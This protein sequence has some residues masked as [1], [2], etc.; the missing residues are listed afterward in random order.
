M[1]ITV[2][3]LK[4]MARSKGF[5]GYSNLRKADLLDMLNISPE[6]SKTKRTR[7]RSRK[8]RRPK[9][10]RSRKERR[11]KRTRS[12]K[13]RRPKR[14]RSRKERRPKRTRS[15]KERHIRT[16]KEY[17]TPSP[18]PHSSPRDV[19]I[20]GGYKF[21][22]GS[23]IGDGACM[24]HSIIQL[25]KHK[26]PTRKEGIEFR[27]LIADS[28]TYEEYIHI[29]DGIKA[30]TDLIGM[31]GIDLTESQFGS[32]NILKI[33]QEF[34][35]KE[36]VLREISEKLYRRYKNE[37][38]STHVNADEFMLAYTSKFLKLNIVVVGSNGTVTSG[39]NMVKSYPTIFLYNYMYSHY[40]PLIGM[41]GQ[42]LFDW[43]QTRDI[44]IDNTY[45]I[46]F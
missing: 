16:R 42:T 9:R 37:F 36:K 8:E 35:G 11:P 33:I 23:A 39:T 45:L 43:N 10:T 31:T 27:R 28:F 12:R 40:D 29:G 3:E 15:R 6:A 17:R 5:K 21:V 7:T 25:L 18:S 2:A 22:K 19:I 24:F 38:R 44:L 46:N 32:M 14:T 20:I 34:P 13:E 1:R 26:K 41:N 4:K 30:I